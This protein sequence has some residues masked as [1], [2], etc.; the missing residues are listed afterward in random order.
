MVQAPAG[1]KIAK[2]KI[3]KYTFYHLFK[4]GYDFRALIYLGEIVK[5]I[6]QFS[7]YSKKMITLFFMKT[8]KRLVTP[9]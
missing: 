9:L 8:R 3:S 4:A 5:S 2:S 7:A 1:Y 6:L